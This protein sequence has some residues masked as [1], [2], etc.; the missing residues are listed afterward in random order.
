MLSTMS[1]GEP[2]FTNH[3]AYV[4]PSPRF[5]KNKRQ[6]LKGKGVGRV[7]VFVLKFHSFDLSV[8]T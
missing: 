7:V 4:Y 8:L 3:C 1:H 6:G 2:F 5:W